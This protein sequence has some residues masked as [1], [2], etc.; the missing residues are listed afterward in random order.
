MVAGAG[1]PVD[2]SH[3]AMGRLAGA[4]WR[5]AAAGAVRLQAACGEPDDVGVYGDLDGGAGGVVV[6]PVGATGEHAG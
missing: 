5:G 2:L 3:F 4:S 6:L 1:L